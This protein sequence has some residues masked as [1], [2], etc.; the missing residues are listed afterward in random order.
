MHWFSL[1]LVLCGLHRVGWPPT[2]EH[3]DLKLSWTLA[4]VGYPIVTGASNP[5]FN[6][7]LTWLIRLSTTWI[8][9]WKCDDSPRGARY[10]I[11][12]SRGTLRF[13]ILWDSFFRLWLDWLWVCVRAS[14]QDT[15]GQESI[16]SC[17][18]E[19]SAEGHCVEIK[20]NW[21]V[22]RHLETINTM[23]ARGA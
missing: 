5:N 19:N 20:I 23:I 22:V 1:Q 13:G 18:S 14:H 8:L 6:F 2:E 17:H 21:E 9:S 12:C 15:V 3:R 7:D 10:R 11:S 4:I 16:C